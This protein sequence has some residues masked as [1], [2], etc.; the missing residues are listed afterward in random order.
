VDSTSEFH[1]P[2][3]DPHRFFAEDWR[4]RP[5]FIRGGAEAFLGRRFLATDFAAAY[6]AAANADD[7][8]VRER[9]G[10]VT[11]IENVSAHDPDLQDRAVQFSRD[12][13]A[14]RAWFDA[15]RTYSASG[16]GAHFDHS[17]N[18]VLQQEGVKYWTL[19]SPEH[20][21]PDDIAKR[22][23]NVP[24][25]GSHEIPEGEGVRFVT[26]P[27]DL[28]YIPLFWL[29]HGVSE[30]ESLSLSLVCPAVSLY[31]AVVPFLSQ[32]VRSRAL[33][34]QPIPALHAYLSAEE[35]SAARSEI[36]MATREL[37]E[38]ISDDVGANVVSV[39]QEKHLPSATM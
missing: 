8:H 6:A 16:I 1:E 24:D 13:A 2:S 33:G 14:P 25:V 17:D 27:G 26:E 35:R 21:S 29:H 31:S 22:M 38:L 12:F 32:A 36:G 4:R 5:L 18:F 7:A 34:H 20:I 11:F 39:L 30:A 19:A 28:L 3:F 37:L 10:E 15:I 9:P 23:L